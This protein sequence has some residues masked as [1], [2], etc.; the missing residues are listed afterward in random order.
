M[1][2]FV[3]TIS[4]LFLNGY[5]LISDIRDKIHQITDGKRS[6]TD[7]VTTGVIGLNYP[8]PPAR[9]RLAPPPPPPGNMNLG[10]NHPR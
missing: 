7:R 1:H 8:P 4:T 2:N 6:Q 10:L 3:Y 9:F 5:N